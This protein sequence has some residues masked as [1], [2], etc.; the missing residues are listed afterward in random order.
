[1][2]G[3]TVFGPFCHQKTSFLE[4]VATSGMLLGILVD[5][6]TSDGQVD[7]YPMQDQIESELLA[8]EEKRQR[9][10]EEIAL[11]NNREDVETL[12]NRLRLKNEYEYLPSL[13]TFRQ[14]PII[15]LLQ[16]GIY[17]TNRGTRISNILQNNQLMRQQLDQGIERWIETAKQDLAVVL[18]FSRQWKSANK[19]VLHPVERC[20]AWFLCTKCG[21]AGNN[22]QTDGSLDFTGACLHVCQDKNKN[23]RF[24]RSKRAAWNPGNFVKDE[25]V[26]AYLLYAEPWYSLSLRPSM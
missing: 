18:G 20:T 4:N 7:V 5:P 23:D 3:C 8:L 16:A 10:K 6:S 19:K 22:S 12:Y 21:T 17:D 2:I 24:R 25:K 1:M 15:Q 26:I 9:R 14:L 13:P 11:T